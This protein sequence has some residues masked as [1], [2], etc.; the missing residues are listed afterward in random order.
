MVACDDKVAPPQPVEIGDL[1]YVN[2]PDGG[3]YSTFYKPEIGWVGDP[4]P[5]YNEADQTFYLFHLQD[6]RDGR[7]N[8]HPIYYT[9]TR[10]YADF[11][12]IQPAIECGDN[13]SFQDL[14]IGTGSCVEYN[15]TYYF[16][17]TGHNDY[18]APKEKI[19]MATSPDLRTWTKRPDFML[20][21]PDGY[22]QNNFR[23]PHVYYDSARYCWVMLVTTIKDG[24]GCLARYTS[25]DLGSWKLIAPLTDFESDAEILECPDIFQMGDKWYLTFSRINRDAQRKTFYRIADSPEGPWRIVRD[26]NNV[27][28]ETFDGLF[29]YAGKTASNGT[30]RYISGWCSSAERVNEGNELQWAGA[31]VSHKIECDASTGRLYAVIPDALNTKL[32]EQAELK[33]IITS[34]NV[35]ADGN[36]FS[37]PQG[38]SAVFAR[39]G[40][41]FR[42]TMTIDASDAD[43]FGLAF[44]ASGTQQTVNKIMFD[45][46]DNNRG[47]PGLF[48]YNGADELNYTPLD[49]PSTAGFEVTVIAEKSICAV[50]VNGTMAFTNRI[51]RMNE[52]PWMIFSD[53]GTARFSDVRVYL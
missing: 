39:N 53:N 23:D 6:W 7:N 51:V 37:V 18:L 40:S 5:F 42:I 25:E 13:I 48:M 21:A 47:R 49:V 27:T 46:T 15:G 36:N 52:N 35:S 32:M 31:L 12:P 16:F 3:L 50:Y 43:R 29:L 17:Y 41:S 22:D 10:D 26:E 20:Q 1:D 34:G 9:T 8:D 38:G 44:D 30:D 2:V 45:L 14:F 4:M 11:T 24:K 28:H 19:M 33:T